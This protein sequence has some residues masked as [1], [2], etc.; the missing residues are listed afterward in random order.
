MTAP[1]ADINNNYG[2]TA[3]NTFNE[4]KE[5]RKRF[6]DASDNIFGPGFLSMVEYYFIE[7]KGNNPFVML[8]S[9]PSIV[10]DEWIKTFRGEEPVRKLFEK[11]I[12]A[13]K[14]AKVME[15]IKRNDGYALRNM[16]LENRLSSSSF[17]LSTSLSSSSTMQ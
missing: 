15:N 5:I 13:D 12:G 2:T 7:K 10:Y 4:F 16:M 17:P 11:A 9:E 3:A 6:M 1:I 8:F 14:T